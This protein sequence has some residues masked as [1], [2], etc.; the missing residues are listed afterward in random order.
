MFSSP[1]PRRP[2]QLHLA[3]SNGCI[4]SVEYLLSTPGINVTPEDRYRNTPLVDAIRHKH[5]D[6]QALL[7][8]ANSQL[9]EVD[10][11]IKLNFAAEANDIES[12]QTLYLN[13]ADFNKGDSL[14]RTPLHSAPPR[15]P[16]ALRQ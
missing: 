8:A 11:D 10:I 3:C 5:K 12:L 14:L 1:P 13:G 9:G 4:D 7:R 15:L 2:C 16:A 6:V